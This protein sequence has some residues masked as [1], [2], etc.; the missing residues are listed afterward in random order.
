MSTRDKSQLVTGGI[1]TKPTMP[2]LAD[3]CHLKH[4]R[5]FPPSVT[6]AVTI[7]EAVDPRELSEAIEAQ[8]RRRNLL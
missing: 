2:M 4:E 1:I 6:T 5:C 7:S 3:C 8:L